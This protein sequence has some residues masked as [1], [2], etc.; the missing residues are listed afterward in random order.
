[1]DRAGDPVH[2]AAAGLRGRGVE[3]IGS[4]RG[5]RVHAE[6]EDQERRHERAASNTGHAD[7][8]AD[9]KPGKRIKRVDH[10]QG[11]VAWS[12]DRA[13]FGALTTI[14]AYQRVSSPLG[15]HARKV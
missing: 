3:E 9:G 10:V 13:S 4:H 6:E 2:Q 1:M 14:R 15:F 11:T 12:T 7:K 5:R 8:E